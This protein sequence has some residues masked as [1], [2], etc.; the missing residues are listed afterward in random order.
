MSQNQSNFVTLTVINQIFMKSKLLICSLLFTL[1]SSFSQVELLRDFYEGENKDGNPFLLGTYKNKMYL[2]ASVAKQ[3]T[4]TITIPEQRSFS[5]D[6]TNIEELKDANGELANFLGAYIP[7]SDNDLMIVNIKI[8]NQFIAHTYDGSSF[9]K[10]TDSRFYG[11]GIKFKN[12]YYFTANLNGKYP[13]FYSDGTEAGT[14][15]LAEDVKTYVN[16]NITERAEVNNILVFAGDTSAEGLELWKTDGTD[17][18]T[19]LL[20]DIHSGSGDSKPEDFFT[21]ADKSLLFFS[22]KTANEGR[23]LWVTDGTEAG[24]KMLNDFHSGTS[25]DNFENLIELNGNVY[26]SINSEVW[27]TDGTP[28]NTTK[29]LDSNGRGFIILNDELFFIADRSYYKTDGTVSGTVK[30]TPNNFGVEWRSFPIVYKNEIYFGGGLLDNNGQID[31]QE[32][33]KT[34]GKENGTVIVKD[35]NP[36]ARYSGSLAARFAVVGEE[37]L[38]FAQTEENGPRL[39]KTDGTEAGTMQA[40]YSVQGTTGFNIAPDLKGVFKDQLLIIANANNGLGK[41][42]Y[43]YKNSGTTAS[44]KTEELNNLMVFST[45]KKL[46]IN[47]IRAKNASLKIYN[48]LGKSLQEIKFS[49]DGSSVININAKPGIYIANI[50]TVNGSNISKKFIVTD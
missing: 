46:Y 10:I 22:A 18:G 3:L 44:I 23:E 42:L 29:L 49:S 2:F 9:T 14:G 17:A 37:L 32:L 43:V 19:L 7:E 28:E 6:G 47:G 26:F 27:V 4:S 21:N 38:F 35:I 11:G 12:K 40:S 34:N 25:G 48:I 16:W 20:K 1:T 24:T 36:N 15:A 5:Y 30:V 39:W 8:N 31:R 45:G 33:W 50:K 13:L 41:E